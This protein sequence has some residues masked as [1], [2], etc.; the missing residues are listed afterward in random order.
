M[1]T[2]KGKSVRPRPPVVTTNDII[3]LPPEL[4]TKGRKVE[5]AINI[6]YINGEALL[7]SVDRLIRYN[8]IV[9][10]GTKK[11]GEMYTATT[12]CAALDNI[13]HLYNKADIYITKI[14]AD[15]EF[16]S[17]FWELDETWDVE[18]N[19]SSPITS[20]LTPENKM[21]FLLKIIKL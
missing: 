21:P 5:I 4:V 18:F 16:K 3:E 6:V 9:S 2:L 20:I 11:K 12:L 7:H 1:E 14:H 15:N 10:L 19:F 13:L 17:V 8:A